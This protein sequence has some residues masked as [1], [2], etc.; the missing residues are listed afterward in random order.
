MIMTKKLEIIFTNI[1]VNTKF[2]ISEYDTM[3]EQKY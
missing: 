1:R 2:S 3:R